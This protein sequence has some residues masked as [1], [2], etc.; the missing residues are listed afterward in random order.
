MTLA[1]NVIDIAQA[2][3]ESRLTALEATPPPTKPPG[4]LQAH[5]DS[6][7]ESLKQ[8]NQQLITLQMKATGARFTPERPRQHCRHSRHGATVTAA[9]IAGNAS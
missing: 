8:N 3:S 4:N 2:A 6:L 9:S 1:S 7:E 5:A